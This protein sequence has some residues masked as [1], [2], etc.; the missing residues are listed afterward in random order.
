MTREDMLKR[1][2]QER[3]GFRIMPLPRFLRAIGTY[4]QL[5]LAFLLLCGTALAIDIAIDLQRGIGSP[6]PPAALMAHIGLGIIAG[7]TEELL[8]RGIPRRWL[9]NGG[10]LAGTVC[11]VVLHQFYAAVTVIYRLPADM[12]MGVFYLKLWRGRLW[13]L[14]LVI[15]PLWNVAVIC[16]W[17]VV[18][19]YAG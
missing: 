1:L 16:G 9:G 14:A 19:I 15:H 6:E 17:Q 3:D 7:V 13:W 8:F 10:L 2:V 11:W 5:L 12:L 4:R 18:K